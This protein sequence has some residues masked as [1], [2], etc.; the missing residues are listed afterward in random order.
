[1][2]EI[3]GQQS[4][5]YCRGQS[6]AVLA[7]RIVHASSALLGS[8][9]SLNLLWTS[10]LVACARP[11]S[12]RRRPVH[13]CHSFQLLSHRNIHDA[14]NEASSTPSL[15]FRRSLFVCL[16]LYRRFA[17]LPVLLELLDF[18]VS[19]TKEVFSR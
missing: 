3:P 14:S 9:G 16:T 10:F 17:R 4:Q 7:C 1:M 11:P 13:F 18:P 15:R 6:S 12:I 2:P 8:R 5:D 19:S